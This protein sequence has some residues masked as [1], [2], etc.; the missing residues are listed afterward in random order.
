[1]IV[2]TF[3][4]TN[5]F[6][7]A[8][9]LAEPDKQQRAIDWITL[10]SDARALSINLQVINEFSAVLLRK[11]P[12]AEM[13][14]IRLAARDMMRWGNRPIDAKIT[15]HAWSIRER[16]NF[17]WF[18]TLLLASAH[19]MRCRHFLSEDMKHGETIDG[20]TIIDAFKTSPHDLFLE[21]H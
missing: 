7:Y 10:L 11:L 2:P 5:I 3:V 17:S 15:A 6:L 13:D 19:R 8:R 18:D 20:V 21:K 4:D 12:K 9:D 1:M 16:H 14:D